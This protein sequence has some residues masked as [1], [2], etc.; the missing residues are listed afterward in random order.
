MRNRA[1]S[2]PV[3]LLVA[4]ALM[5]AG[6]CS[7]EARVSGSVTFDNQPLN[8]GVVSF[9]PV[10]EGPVA[11]GQIDDSGNYTV[12]VGSGAGL[13]PGEYVVTVVA[14]EPLVQPKDPRMAPSPGKRITPEKY[15]AKEKS[16]L[17]YTVKPGSNTIDL[18]ISSK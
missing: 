5:A 3:A 18:S 13:P 9:H 10:G 11:L 1:R 7:G 6:G 14:N 2:W 8:T 4:G 15:A 16:D 12:A 17:K